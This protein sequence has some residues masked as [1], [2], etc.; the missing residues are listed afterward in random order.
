MKRILTL[1]IIGFACSLSAADVTNITIIVFATKDNGNIAVKTNVLN[2]GELKTMVS[3]VA[4]NNAAAVLNTNLT[5]TTEQKYVAE[6]CA[7]RIKRIRAIY[8]NAKKDRLLNIVGHITDDSNIEK[9]EDEA[10]KYI[11]K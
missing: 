5:S 10:K 4:S 11:S 7:D 3:I 1:I 9:V 2:Q 8:I 6:L